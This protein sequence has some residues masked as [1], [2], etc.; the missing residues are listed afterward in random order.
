MQ[1]NCLP[2]QKKKILMLFTNKIVYNM[3]NIYFGN[4][5]LQWTESIKYIGFISDIKLN[6]NQQMHDVSS[7][8]S[9][10]SGIM[11]RLKNFLQKSMLLKIYNNLFHPYLIQS[12]VI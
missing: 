2:T 7:K 1:I 8:I 4:D 10:Y 6:F 12:I 9:K 5:L 11:Y 3:I